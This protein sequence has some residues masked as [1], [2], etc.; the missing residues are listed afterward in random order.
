VIEPTTQAA[1]A[2]Y[3]N[4]GGYALILGSGVSRGAQ[5]KTGYEIVLDLADQ[6]AR[7]SGEDP[8]SDPAAWYR[9]KFGEEPDY[10]RLLERMGPT[11]A[12]RQS[13]LRHYF[14]P[15]AEERE[16][17]EKVPTPAHHSIAQL[18]AA[19]YVRVIVTP[20]FDRLLEDALTQAGVR[21][22]VVRSGSD[23]DGM[24][25]IA[26]VQCVVVKVHGDY[27]DTRIR[28]TPAELASYE[29]SIDRLLDRLFDD[30]GLIVCGWSSDW[31]QALRNAVRRIANRRLT[32]F[33]TLRGAP[34]PAAADLIANRS[35]IAVAIRDADEFFVDLLERVEAIDD[36]RQRP[37]LTVELA[38]AT[39]KRYLVDTSG[40]IR[41]R[42]LVKA[43]TEAVLETMSTLGP[44]GAQPTNDEFERRIRLIEAA[45]MKLAA[46][47]A[48]GCFWGEKGHLPIWTEALERLGGR[49][50]DQGAEPLYRLRGYAGTIVMYSGA[51]GALGA[52]RY[53]TLRALLLTPI[54]RRDAQEAAAFALEVGQS[55]EYEAMNR[56]RKERDNTPNMTFHVPASERLIGVV[57]DALRDTIPDETRFDRLYYRAETL[58]SLAYAQDRDGR[59]HG[60]WF[61]P[62]LHVFRTRENIAGRGTADL[63]G[64]ELAQEGDAWPPVVSGL[65]PSATRAKELLQAFRQQ[66]SQR[67]WLW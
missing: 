23:A 36:L 65:L 4:R 13:I 67:G 19:G 9:G 41:L 54:R 34:S 29:P 63:M 42:D 30:Y 59:G 15:S 38:L 44:D 5:I 20:N 28:N 61:P 18:V 56:L 31:D 8:G 43:E 47:V 16:R 62:G 37:P 24:A 45:T 46:I 11:A 25:P 49:G 32:T 27:L 57:H 33:W 52:G 10:S 66:M 50:Y 53:D 21:P 48:A 35:A 55:L 51:V 12:E 64:E 1:F 58:I 40:R 7:V 14:E 17:G 39:A 6:I 26:Q 60:L 22:Y 3:S 2:L